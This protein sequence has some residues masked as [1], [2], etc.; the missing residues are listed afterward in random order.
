MLKLFNTL[1]KTVEPF[2]PLH[3]G[4]V[5]MYSCGP[6]VYDYVHIGNIRAYIF[7]DL[8]KRYLLFS[9]YKLT[10]VMNITDV[11]DKTIK[12]SQSLGKSLRD[13]TEFYYEEFLK[14][15]ESVNI[16]PADILPKA[17]DHVS[18]MTKMIEE[19]K[20]K[21]FAYS[22]D[23]S[24]YYSI[25]KFQNYGQLAGLDH[26]ETM[27]MQ[28]EKS[29]EYSK[30]SVRDFALWK[31]WDSADG[32]VFWETTLGKGRPGWHIECS[33]MSTKYLGNSFDIHCGGVDLIFPH[34]TNEIAQTEAATNEPFVKYWLHNEHLLVEGEKM[35]KSLN[36]FITLQQLIDEGVNPILVRILLQKTHYRQRL[37]FTRKGL[38]E[39]ASMADR[40]VRAVHILN[41]SASSNQSL[42]IDNFIK[43]N[44][45]A[46][47]LAMDDDLNISEAYSVL[48][49]VIEF[50]E[51]NRDQI[52]NELA[53][54]LKAHLDHLDE[55]FG[56]INKLYSIYT[57]KLELV[58]ESTEVLN[59]LQKR[60]EYRAGK[61]YEKADEVRK[62]LALK[63]VIVK[64]TPTGTTI[65][66][67]TIF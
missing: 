61:N 41:Q 32:D 46:F 52:T 66:L 13:F 64:D 4:K 63:N 34:H 23:G 42:D 55:V 67:I 57:E 48:F 58:N 60:G 5:G 40:I 50:I 2:I 20:E 28:T 26:V 22:L 62:E 10:H 36:N 18:E 25:E 65:D 3:E 44:L 29:D 59:L 30:E 31:G 16:L 37:N 17:T 27:N 9:G 54:K 53:S 47:T 51:K 35:S 1:T 19:L 11:D 56:F 8:L 33:A 14:N 49:S 39:V 15:L 38:S 24:T 12:R 21:G 6:T 7:V 43:S 45:E